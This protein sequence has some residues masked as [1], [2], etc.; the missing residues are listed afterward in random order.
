MVYKPLKFTNQLNLTTLKMYQSSLQYYHYSATSRMFMFRFEIQFE[1]I[2]QLLI[3]SGFLDT[4]LKLTK[5][6]LR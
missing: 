1:M 2:N 5:N 4:Q 3:I 6:K